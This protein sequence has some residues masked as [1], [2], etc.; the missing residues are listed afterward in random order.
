MGSAYRWV[1]MGLHGQGHGQQLGVGHA[2]T[3]THVQSF[4]FILSPWPP[5]SH[6]LQDPE[7]AEQRYFRH[8]WGDVSLLKEE[9]YAGQ[10][11]AGWPRKEGG[12]RISLVQA[13][14]FDW[15]RT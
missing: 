12:F 3:C 6:H 4:F 11:S 15:S 9:G 8:G 7:I 13:P 1:C 14:C 5:W 10:V 2:Y